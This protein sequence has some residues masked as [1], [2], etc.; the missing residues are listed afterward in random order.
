MTLTELLVT[1]IVG[2]LFLGIVLSS[3][4]FSY[5]NWSIERTRARLRVNLAVVMERI[6]EEMRLSSLTYTSFYPSGA[7]EYT[8]ISFPMA[9]ADTNDSRFLDLDDD[10]YIEWDKSIIYHIFENPQDSGN[11]ELRRTEFTGNYAYLIDETTRNKQLSDLVQYGEAQ[12]LTPNKD[13]ANTETILKSI[14]SFTIKSQA[15]LFDGYSSTIQRSDRV[16]FGNIKLDYGEDGYHDFKFEVVGKNASS[17]GRKFGIDVLS[18]T[19]SGYPREA[20]FYYPLS[21]PHSDSGDGCSNMSMSGWS[22]NHYLEYSSDANGDFINLH[23]YYDLWRESNFDNS[24]RDN[25][26]LVGDDLEIILCTPKQGGMECWS[27]ITEAGADVQTVEI[28]LSSANGIT[29]RDIL[30][31]SNIERT[32]DLIRIKFQNLDEDNELRIRKAYIAKRDSSGDGDDAV[33]GSGVQL[34]FSDTPLANGTTEPEEYG[35]KVGDDGGSALSSVTMLTDS[36]VY[37]NWAECVIEEGEDYFVTAY[38]DNGDPGAVSVFLTTWS[39]AEINSYYLEEDYADTASWSGSTSSTNIYFTE[40][41]DN[42]PNQGTVT[43]PAYDTKLE[44]PNYDEINWDPVG[45]PVGSTISLSARSSDNADMSGATAWVTVANGGSLSSTLDNKRYIQ[46]LATLTKNSDYD[47]YPNYPAID[48]VAINW[49]GASTMCEVSGYFT[50]KPD[51]GIIKLTVDGQGVTKGLEFSIS[52][53]EELQGKTYETSLTS[54]IE[55][56]NTG[57]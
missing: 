29:V 19:P 8:A 6:K 42:W 50:K 26:M 15:Q 14:D 3:W 7:L 57:R 38:V 13:N 45:A 28:P 5:K 46:F 22:G 12:A 55:P 36:Y 20:E 48:N 4:Y 32:G 39:G 16:S 43:S 2:T 17:S 27:A 37:S 33:D 51:Y 53:S 23:L 9:K 44:S 35:L 34:F 30:S 10:G 1:L 54:E 31:T 24:V 11:Y 52:L 56:R 47:D 40:S 18:I 25:T 21:S 41:A 49:P